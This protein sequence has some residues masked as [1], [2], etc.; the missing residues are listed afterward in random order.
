MHVLHGAFMPLDEDGKIKQWG[1]HPRQTSKISSKLNF[2]FQ[3]ISLLNNK[4]LNK[5]FVYHCTMRND[6]CWGKTAMHGIFMPIYISML[7]L[8]NEE[9]IWGKHIFCLNKFHFSIIKSFCTIGEVFCQFKPAMYVL[10]GVFILVEKD[11]K[12]KQW[13]Y[14]QNQNFLKQKFNFSIVSL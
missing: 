3:K 2:L 11:V 14:L 13:S 10:R 8:D 12:M 9:S 4:I 6:F 7:S 1:K 5:S